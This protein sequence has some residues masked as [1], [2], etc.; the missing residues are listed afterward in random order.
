M[1]QEEQLKRYPFFRELLRE[2]PLSAIL[3]SLTGVVARPY[4]LRFIRS[5]IAEGTP[6][7]MSIVDLDNFKSVND[8]YGHRTGDAVL[9]GV[10]GDLRT[11]V[12]ERGV[13]GRFGGDE[14]LFVWFGGTGYDEVHAFFS[15]MF[16]RQEVFRR[17]CRY[18]DAD[19]TMTGT[20]GIVRFPKDAPDFSTL[21][22]LA[23]KAL[24]RGK[25]KGRNCFI[26]YLPEKHAHLNIPSLA[27][28]R[29]TERSSS[30]AAPSLAVA[31]TDSCF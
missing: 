19:L 31:L 4:M 8:N 27:V 5:L 28:G 11:Y 24:Y 29:T 14:F 20:C 7:T 16:R 9:T 6:F 25:T 15:G 26:I 12:G 1:Y 23:D 18:G 13:V 10:C 17:E 30:G 22:S 2:A 21:F 3:D